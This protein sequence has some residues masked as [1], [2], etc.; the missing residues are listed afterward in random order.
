MI[1]THINCIKSFSIL[2]C[3][4]PA[5]GTP[6][7]ANTNFPSIAVDASSLP[8]A[9]STR[10]NNSMFLT[11]QTSRVVKHA[12]GWLFPGNFHEQQTTTGD[13]CPL[14]WTT[15]RWVVWLQV[16]LGHATDIVDAA[17]CSTLCLCYPLWDACYHLLEV[18]EVLGTKIY[19]QIS[20][21]SIS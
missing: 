15:L 10:T 4:C 1:L 16:T 17:L 21:Q 18:L 11:S 6:W 9:S 12:R 19:S 7:G 2:L 20:Q 13:A 8:E 3:G 5:P 14:S